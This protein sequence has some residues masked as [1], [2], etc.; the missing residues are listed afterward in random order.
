MKV[1]Q[2]ILA[3]RESYAESMSVSNRNC[4]WLLERADLKVFLGS[5]EPGSADP[6]KW[7]DRTGNS[8]LPRFQ[9]NTHGPAVIK[10]N[11][12]HIRASIKG[13]MNYR[14][15][16]P[17]LSNKNL[18][19]MFATD[20]SKFA[21]VGPMRLNQLFSS[22]CLTGV[23]PLRAMADCIS[24]SSSTNPGKLLNT[25]KK[26]TERDLD[27]TLE[28]LLRT[29]KSHGFSNLT[30]FFLENMLCEMFRHLDLKTKKDLKDS[31]NK[32]ADVCCTILQNGMESPEYLEKV[33]N[34]T[35]S[36]KSDVY[37]KDTQK[38]EW[39]HLFSVIERKTIMQL[40]M[41]PSTAINIV[42]KT[43]NVK[44]HVT[45]DENSAL[46]VECAPKQDFSAHFL[47]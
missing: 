4:F 22:L 30:H 32:N 23:F 17:T 37:F 38:D 27:A 26:S 24:I 15:A 47:T 34:A 28:I 16:N 3:D 9:F 13:I 6:T 36:S 33:I 40:E 5:G 43:C 25:Y 20:L 2:N 29:L 41:R 44:V 10:K 21:G 12:V 18:H 7:N 39:Q 11:I 31:K 14:Q 35:K 8:Q 45:Y 42:K 1:W 46:I 19:D